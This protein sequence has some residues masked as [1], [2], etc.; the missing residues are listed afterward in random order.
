MERRSGL[1]G[2][3]F[4]L[5]RWV[6]LHTAGVLAAPVPGQ[7]AASDDIYSIAQSGV[8][9]SYTIDP[10]GRRLVETTTTGSMVTNTLTRHYTDSSDNPSWIV[11]NAE[12][13]RYTPALGSGL[14]AVVYP[15][16][17]IE[18]TVDD[19]HGDVVTT[20][21]LPT[22]GDVSGI[23]GWSMFD[24][25]GNALTGL[26][27]TG[28]ATYGWVGSQERATLDNGLI[29]MGAR[30]YNSVT[31]RFLSPDP[32]AGGNENSYN[33]P[34]DP[35]NR[36]DTTGMFDW[37]LALEI[38][39]LVLS[40]VPGLGVA[41]LAA[42][43]IITAV[44]VVSAIS[45]ISKAVKVVKTVGAIVSKGSRA[46]QSTTKTG[47]SKLKSIGSCGFKSFAGDVDVLLA[48]GE[49]KPI[50]DVV[51]GDEVMSEDPVT[52]EQ[53]A[54]VVTALWKHPDWLYELSTTVGEVTTTEDHPFW[55]QTDQ[56]WQEIQQF[57]RGDLVTTASETAASVRG[58]I[59]G[60]GQY[61]VAYNLT[62]DSTHTYFVATD[63]AAI[64]VHNAKCRLPV[65]PKVT[66]KGQ[67]VKGVQNTSEG[68][69][70]G[71]AEAEAAAR[72]DAASGGGRA[73][74]R[75]PCASGRHVHVDWTNNRGQIMKTGH[76]RW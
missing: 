76:Y 60:S 18:L 41:A 48:D 69:F 66:P 33:Y 53:S 27:D 71:R 67:K 16:A 35:V 43:V 14:G 65:K 42:K 38:G 44:R 36:F 61:G 15:D 64:L 54:Q 59:Y 20:V 30:V 68:K 17:H 31:G 22:S 57:D 39:L 6:A 25:Y 73:R 55:N 13:A 74:F 29:L 75:G 62:I 9:T 10:L 3:P 32:V 8:E 72:R 34:N 49:K 19:P 58:F 47:W 40:F 45:K 7:C 51:I 37:M 63:E 52:G 1:F 28:A 23:T 56:E 26:A 5:G 24:E 2:S 12:T 4:H 46:V 70:T 50:A 21:E 11:E